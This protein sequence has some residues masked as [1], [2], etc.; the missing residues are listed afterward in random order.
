M[1]Y[2]IQP[3]LLVESRKKVRKPCLDVLLQY[4]FGVDELFPDDGGIVFHGALRE[5]AIPPC[6]NML[7]IGEDQQDAIISKHEFH[8]V[9]NTVPVKV[10]V[11]D[12]F[13]RGK[14]LHH[15]KDVIA[16][17]AVDFPD[18][19]ADTLQQLAFFDAFPIMPRIG[20]FIFCLDEF[21]F[22]EQG[23]DPL[24]V[25]SS[26]VQWVSPRSFDFPG[27]SVRTNTGPLFDPTR[28]SGE[29]QEAMMIP[30]SN[31]SPFTI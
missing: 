2:L 21:K 12:F 28:S 15:F 27:T 16:C 11:E 1:Q 5:I 30:G 9:L 14:I 23:I 25:P 3:E 22:R 29:F 7:C 10:D 26:L 20:V 17:G 18:D 24:I 6:R 19:P 31:E 4:L 13:L 8:S